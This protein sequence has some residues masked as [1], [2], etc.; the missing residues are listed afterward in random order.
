MVKPSSKAIQ[1]DHRVDDI[2]NLYEEV[3]VL[4]EGAFAVTFEAKHP[5]T[6]ESR[7]LK[8]INKRPP[9]EMRLPRFRLKQMFEQELEILQ[10]VHHEGIQTP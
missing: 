10:E 8:L 6:G 4:G 2:W 3:K 5:E 1:A 9:P 7:A